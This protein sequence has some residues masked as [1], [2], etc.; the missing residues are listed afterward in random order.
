MCMVETFYRRL[1]CNFHK[2]CILNTDYGKKINK[3]NL[4]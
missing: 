2:Y 1:F 3:R 4:H